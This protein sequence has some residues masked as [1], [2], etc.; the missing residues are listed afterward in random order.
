MPTGCAFKRV[1]AF[2][3]HRSGHYDL[4]LL[5]TG[6]FAAI[7]IFHLASAGMGYSFY[8]AQ[9]LGTAVEFAHG[10]I[11]LL[12]P[13]IVGF[14]AN[15]SPTPLEL[16]VWQAAAGMVFKAVS[17][18]W[19]GWANLVSLLFF[20]TT[21]WPLF[22]IARQHIDERAAWWTL[23]FY[24]TQPLIIIYAGKAAS[25]G[26]CLATAIWFLFFADR[27]IRET[28]WYWWPL[29]ASFACLCAISKLPFFIVAGMVSFFILARSPVRKWR[30]WFLLISAGGVAAAVFALW[31]H[32]CDTQAAVAEFPY[33]E[34]RLS[35]N[36]FMLWFYF[37][38]L[39]M[40]ASL[41][42]W[43]MGGWRFVHATLGSLLLAPLF[44]AALFYSGNHLAK[45]WL[46][47]SSL[48]TLVFFHLVA[49]H[50]HYY[51][52]FS[53][54]VA[55]LCGAMFARAEVLCVQKCSSPKFLVPLVGL[56]L[57]GSA[58]SGLMM[59]NIALYYDYFPHEIS[60]LLKRYTRPEDRLIIY[61]CDTEWP[62]EL[63]S[64]ADRKG[65]YVP[66]IKRE[67]LGPTDSGLQE[68]LDN[69][70]DLQRLRALGYTKLVLVSESPVLFAVQASKPG[71]RQLRRFYPAS[72]SPTVDAWPVV[73][74][75]DDLL[76]KD[77]PP[78][79]PSE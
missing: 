45:S 2:I 37:G 63:L 76:I 49:I 51:L 33:T 19:Y 43:I 78:A 18:N 30:P 46:L 67:A 66:L 61:K 55:L 58:I 44:L 69:K 21:L 27:M 60:S 4:K 1:L 74:R 28:R 20:A 7:T 38:D 22:Q 72:I 39:S 71:S 5:A 68:I 10:S 52:I 31:T 23:V 62:G 35:K 26:F 53:P 70:N 3:N 47:A 8:R 42:T 32:Y 54:G 56:V 34:L 77:I 12:K 29:S 14:N 36:P 13:V 16:P 73:Y 48:M 59:M 64:L 24:L 57:I 17:S 6:L 9:H 40:R 79:R 15:G 65:L 50:W 41:G 75:S 25:D 11:N